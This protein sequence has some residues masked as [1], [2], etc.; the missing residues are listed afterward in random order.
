MSRLDG[1]VA[2]I[3]G[4]SAG[5]G[6]GTVERFVAEGAKVL[7]ADVQVERGEELA[8]SL[9]EDCGF[10]RTDVSSEADI[11]RAVDLAV[12]RYGR[13]DC[14]F[15]NAGYVGVAGEI[16]QLEF[17][18]EYRRTIDVLL[19]G[20]IMGMKHAA[21]VM[22]QQEGGGS[23]ISTASV[24]GLR[25]DFGPH[26][27]CAVKAGVISVTKSVALELGPFGIRVN[28]I[29]PGGIATEIFGG[30][31]ELTEEQQRRVPEIV[32]GV[33]SMMQAVPRAGEP[34]DIASMAVFLAS[35]DSSFVSGQSFVV[36]GGLLAGNVMPP[37]VEHP[38]R[39]ALEAEFGPLPDGT[40]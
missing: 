32:R 26:V 12:E 19:T 38:L 21:R 30:L 20:P 39:T 6:R 15:S 17:G 37:E 5:I 27:Y 9:G 7:V 4:G 16:D 36:D 1:K 34:A 22:K 2:V 33:L 11:E 14:L 29:C 23:I 3:T 18:D 28:A 8:H 10:V 40:L 24:A 35:D 31:H 13:L 25:G